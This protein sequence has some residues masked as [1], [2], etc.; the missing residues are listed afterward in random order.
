MTVKN[1]RF[2]SRKSLQSL[3][4]CGLSLFLGHMPL[5]FLDLSGVSDIIVCLN[6]LQFNDIVYMD[7][8]NH[9]L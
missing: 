2:Q 8:L 6:D 7:F 5:S 1:M 4:C 3:I 9:K